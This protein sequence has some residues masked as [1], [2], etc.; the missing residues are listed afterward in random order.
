MA[1]V[2]A[3][4]PIR[5]QRLATEDHVTQSQFAHRVSGPADSL[6]QLVERRRRL[7][8]DRHLLTDQQFDH[9]FW[10]SRGE[11]VHDHHPAPGQQRSP[12]LPH[13]EVECE[14][15]EHRPDV[16]AVESIEIGR[17]VQQLGD[18][19]VRDANALRRSRRS[20][21]VDD[22]C[23]VVHVQRQEP[24]VIGDRC[25]TAFGHD[26]RFDRDRRYVGHREV[27]LIFGPGHHRNR[28][29]VGQHEREPFGGVGRV[30]RQVAGSG[31]EY[32][33][34]RDHQIS[35]PR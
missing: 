35:R 18:V 23:G 6:D 14:G 22:V 28:P 4:E 1:V 15:M 25:R 33:K 2:P 9:R 19:A 29:R 26:R 24:V 17:I 31:R 3:A 8:E 10:R 21:C 34:Q 12:Q 7:I 16:R 30:D 20:R 13:R 5:I 11:E 27:A 32:R